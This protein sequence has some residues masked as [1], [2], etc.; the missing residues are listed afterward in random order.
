MS[1]IESIQHIV[2]ALRSEMSGRLNTRPAKPT[3]LA[4][5]AATAHQARLEDLIAR[6]VGEIDPHD[7]QKGR[8]A[9]R[10][11]LELTLLDELGE[12]LIND[13]AFYRLVDRVQRAMEQEPR[14]A[15]AIERAV[16]QLL[17]PAETPA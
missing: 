5:S 6:R 2:T 17:P 12:D 15:G 3:R 4:R 9:F 14:I 16:A 1:S 11:F 10:I 7:R 8:K 13:P